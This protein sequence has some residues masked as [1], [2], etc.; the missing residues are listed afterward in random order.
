MIRVM[1]ILAIGLAFAGSGFAIAK[2]P[3]GPTNPHGT[4]K[5]PTPIEREYHMEPTAEPRLTDSVPAM[6]AKRLTGDLVDVLG[7][8]L[9]WLRGL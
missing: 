7:R 8:V 5:E 3:G 6:P 9:P 2:P 1:G 4:G